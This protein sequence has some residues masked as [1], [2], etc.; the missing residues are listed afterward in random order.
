MPG[1]QGDTSGLQEGGVVG[2]KGKK[3]K[4]DE[5]KRKKEEE[6]KRKEEE[7]ERE[8]ERKRL[9]KLEKEKKKTEDK[10]DRM[11]RIFIFSLPQ[12]SRLDGVLR[13]IRR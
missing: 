4:E 1:Y 10:T 12:N 7:K 2:P 5:K 3:E 11:V 8:K 9:E 13:I 6:R